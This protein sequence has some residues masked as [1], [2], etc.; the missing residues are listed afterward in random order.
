M[1]LPDLKDDPHLKVLRPLV[2]TYLAF[3]RADSRH[4]RSLR[5]TPSQFDVIATLGDTKGLTCAELSTA[6][7]VTKGTLT[8]VLDR[9]EAKG[10]IRR[11][12]V[13]DDRRSTRICLTAKGNKLFQTTF[14]AHIAFL[15]PFFQRALS[16]ADAD[17]LRTLL[18]R[19]HRSFQEK[20]VA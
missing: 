18:L 6:T 4:V 7:L 19:L 3:W 13:A 14:A 2:E 5:L 17:Q 16:A 11:T 9:L 12:P 1:D 8:G 20:P 10:L 15:R